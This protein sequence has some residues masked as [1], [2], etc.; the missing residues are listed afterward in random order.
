MLLYDGRGT[1]KM[2]RKEMVLDFFKMLTDK[3]VKEAY[4][5]YIAPEFKHHNPYFAGDRQTLLTAHIEAHRDNPTST[6]E[7]KQ[8]FEDGDYVITHSLVKMNKDHLGFSPV[9]IFKFK[10]SKVVELWDII[11]E[12]Q[13]NSPNEN[14][15]F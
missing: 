9:H 5:K 14:G 11:S 3:K 6:I 12:I 1:V 2:N 13:E 4:D 7:V 8:I 15:P 10:G